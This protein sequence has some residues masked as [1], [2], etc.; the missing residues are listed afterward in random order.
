MQQYTFISYKG[1][2]WLFA[3]LAGLV[4]CLL[5]Y[6]MNEPVG[7]RSGSTAVGYF[8]GIVSTL[9]IALLMAYGV[10]KRAYA[11]ALGTVEGWLAAHVWIGIGLLVLVPLHA[12]FSF[13]CNVHTL[14]YLLMVVTILTGIWG[15]F[16]YATLSSKI[17][18]HRGGSKD[19]LALEQIQTLS[20]EIEK[21]CEGKS[22]PFV[23]LMNSFDI[24]FKPRLSYLI[25][26][27]S[28]PP[29]NQRV[30]GEAFAKLPESER[31]DALRCIGLI[32][33]KI[34]LAQ[35]VVD[36]GRIKALLRAW[37]FVHVPVS[38]ALCAAVTIHIV[39]VFFFR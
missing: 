16:N 33:Q 24:S 36:Q 10:R 2:R 39:S 32:D 8:L 19:A 9:G 22:D 5:L 25:R 12:G 34:G 20:G 7:G 13:G 15:T 29:V 27:E 17:T 35:T 26:R 14:A 18:A 4:A 38:I 30:A 31:E 3:T 23:S 1:Y 28:F 6:V 37:L 11:S 21:V